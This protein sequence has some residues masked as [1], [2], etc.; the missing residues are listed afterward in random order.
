MFA[1]I[2]EQSSQL[3]WIPV[4]SIHFCTRWSM[5]VQEDAFSQSLWQRALTPNELFRP[6][7]TVFLLKPVQ[8][9]MQRAPRY[10]GT[11]ITSVNSEIMPYGERAEVAFVNQSQLRLRVFLEPEP[12]LDAQHFKFVMNKVY[13]T[14]QYTVYTAYVRIYCIL[15]RLSTCI[16]SYIPLNSR[17]HLWSVCLIV[18]T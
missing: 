6:G 1:C 9:L 7:A 11:T 8:C 5:C 17:S 3:F 2:L 4:Q 10:G 18:V 12:A 14:I 15:M 13:T 16:V